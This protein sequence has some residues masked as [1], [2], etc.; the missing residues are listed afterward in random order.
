MGNKVG[1]YKERFATC[2]KMTRWDTAPDSD[3]VL[4]QFVWSHY[5][6]HSLIFLYSSFNLS[7]EANST[8][9]PEELGVSLLDQVLNGTRNSNFYDN[10][11]LIKELS[12][13]N[14][15]VKIIHSLHYGSI[16]ILSVLVAEV[17][18]I[19]ITF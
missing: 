14:D 16:S 18:M 1:V 7:S 4:P 2:G 8:D 9:R 6:L 5:S 19:S 13:F 15:A 17:R 3:L 12:T 10:S 11:S